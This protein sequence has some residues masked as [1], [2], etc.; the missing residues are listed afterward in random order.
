MPLNIYFLGRMING[1]DTS[2]SRCYTYQEGL[3]HFWIKG[4]CVDTVGLYSEII[5]KY[6]KYQGDSDKDKE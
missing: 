5:R 3:S 4:Y 2:L 1:Y 6:G